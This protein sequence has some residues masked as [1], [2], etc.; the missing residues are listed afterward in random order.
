VTFNIKRSFKC[1][2]KEVVKDVSFYS[3]VSRF[4]TQ[5]AEVGNVWPIFHYIL[6][7]L[8]PLTRMFTVFTIQLLGIKVL[9][10]FSTSIIQVQHCKALQLLKT[11]VVMDNAQTNISISLIKICRTEMA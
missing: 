11:T 4:H 10:I 5:D 8:L 6:C 7:T 3:V 9:F 2:L 1:R